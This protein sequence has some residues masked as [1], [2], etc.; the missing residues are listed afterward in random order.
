VE[1]EEL[2][3]QYSRNSGIVNKKIHK[4]NKN[5]QHVTRQAW[6]WLS[7]VTADHFSLAWPRF[8]SKKNSSRGK[9]CDKKQK[10]P[11]RLYICITTTTTITFLSFN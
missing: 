10:E 3:C 7:T 2:F 11:L 8:G 9:R 6:I 5:R 4:K 1:L